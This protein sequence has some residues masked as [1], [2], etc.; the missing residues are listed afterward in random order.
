MGVLQ[1]AFIDGLVFGVPDVSGAHFWSSGV[2]RF[3]NLRRPGAQDGPRWNLARHRD[4]PEGKLF[5]ALATFC[6]FGDLVGRQKSTKDRNLAL[7]G[8]PGSDVLAINRFSHFFHRFLM[9]T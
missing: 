7:N 6:I 2:H 3:P 1:Q 8:V 4:Q 9:K 5:T